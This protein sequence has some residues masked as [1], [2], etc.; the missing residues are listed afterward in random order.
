MSNLVNNRF[1]EIGRFG[2]PRGLDGN[3]RFQPNENFVDGIFDQIN[4]YYMRN[5]RSDLIPA[6]IESYRVEKKRNQHTFFVKF[7][8]I[9]NRD[10]ADEAMNKA[11]FV[12]NEELE[13]L[14]DKQEADSVDL[15]GYHVY[16]EN[17]NVGE[18]LDLYENPAHPILEIKYQSGSL[19]IPMVDEYIDRVDHE[20]GSVH[21]KN[22]NQ[23]TEEG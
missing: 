2:R 9:A 1:I 15:I 13:N 18:V 7:D 19:L 11:L 3:I 4:L 21:C 6:R 22:L 12:V 16:S 14:T 17:Q 8:L 5:N 10:D 20:H 23:L